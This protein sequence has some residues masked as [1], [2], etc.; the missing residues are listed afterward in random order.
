MGPFRL[1]GCSGVRLRLLIAAAVAVT[2]IAG[3]SSKTDP[4]D[5]NPPDL[6]YVSDEWV[7]KASR[8]D[9]EGTMRILIDNGSPHEL[10]VRPSESDEFSVPGGGRELLRVRRTNFSLTLADPEEQP[11]T[12][13]FP[14]P[15]SDLDR[16]LY[17]YNHHGLHDY[18][19][20]SASYKAFE[21]FGESADLPKNRK[22]I[23]VM[24][25]LAGSVDMILEALPETVET[26]SYEEQ[27]LTAINHLPSDVAARN[28]LRLDTTGQTA[29][30]VVITER[31]EAVVQPLGV[32]E[33]W[34]F[35][36]LYVD[37]PGADPLS[38]ELEE[39]ALGQV[40]ADGFMSLHMPAGKRSLRLLSNGQEKHALE[41]SFRPRSKYVWSPEGRRQFSVEF[42]Q[43]GRP[44][45]LVDSSNL[46]MPHFDRSPI[47]CRAARFFEVNV[48]LMFEEFPELW[49]T[50]VESF[51]GSRLVSKYAG[52]F[53]PALRRELAEIVPAAEP[54]L[55][56]QDQAEL[57]RYVDEL[58][59]KKHLSEYD[60]WEAK[61]KRHELAGE[62]GHL[63]YIRKHFRD[64]SPD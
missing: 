55:D 5:A 6:E 34:T 14:Q 17:V 60:L 16:P 22:V 21:D 59:A 64:V 9:D 8:F 32:F 43:Y 30:G 24:A 20:K 33:D 3:C 26:S 46:Y 61:E 53:Q 62:E 56:E 28:W 35:S 37:N 58:L 36:H 10:T 54:F 40:A 27:I 47:A 23:G 2:L 63:A 48:D 25:F 18:A 19:V 50:K 45:K 13:E 12:V 39:L 51:E 44:Q 31:N 41:F 1:P 42:E 38:L 4:D 7:W 11:L 49:Q 29:L 57:A 52:D 15:D